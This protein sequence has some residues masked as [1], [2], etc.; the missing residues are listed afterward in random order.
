LQRESCKN[1][2]ESY[3]ATA[4]KH[5]KLSKGYSTQG[6]LT[7]DPAATFTCHNASTIKKKKKKKQIKQTSYCK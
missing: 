5:N 6:L 2:L 4:Y 3:Y 7:I 1:E